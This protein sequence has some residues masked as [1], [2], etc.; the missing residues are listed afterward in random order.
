MADMYLKRKEKIIIS[1]IDI[2]DELGTQ[3][4]TTK[5]I[6][7]RQGITEPAVY[8]QFAGKRDIILAILE[9]FSEFDRRI[10]NT[11]LEQ[12]MP[13]L[14]GLLFY[15]RSY[16]EYYENYPQ[17]AAVLFS[18]DMYRN[19][20]ETAEKMRRIVESRS[21]FV[22]GLVKAGQEAGVISS[23]LSH[24]DFADIILSLIWSLTFSWKV[25]G[26]RGSLKEKLLAGISTVLNAS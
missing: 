11:I 18:Y 23:R 10:E 21:R 17:I 12:S 2:L 20:P 26:C 14:E 16:A 24:E 3:G 22:S 13:A 6:A 15:T 25:G 19:E 9:K 7:R 8:R 1:A 5:E 4:L